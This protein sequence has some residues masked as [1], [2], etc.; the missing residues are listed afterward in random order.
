[1]NDEHDGHG[2]SYT[3]D[4]KTGKRTLIERTKSPASAEPTTAPV[5]ERKPASVSHKGAMPEPPQG[6]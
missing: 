3:V 1:M 4:P 2:G 5:T 6:E